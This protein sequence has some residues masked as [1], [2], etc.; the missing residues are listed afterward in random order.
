MNTNNFEFDDDF[1]D[2]DDD[3][4][5]SDLVGATVKIPSSRMVRNPRG[6]HRTGT[7]GDQHSYD[8]EAF[9]E[10]GEILDVDE[11]RDEATV[12]NQGLN[13]KV[14]YRLSWLKDVNSLNDEDEDEFDDDEDDLDI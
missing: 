12:F 13:K 4:S 11:E 5:Q 14:N 6:Q 1:D 9:E 10:D 7:W 2:D 8:W 3:E